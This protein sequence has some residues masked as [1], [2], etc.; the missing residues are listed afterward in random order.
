MVTAS[1]VGYGDLG[2]SPNN[3][4]S[5]VFTVF[6]IFVGVI[7]VFAQL[8][9]IVSKFFRPVFRWTRNLLETVFPQEAIDI[10]GDGSQ[11]FKVPR[12]PLIY[13]SKNLAM[14][15]AFII[16]MQ[17]CFAAVF[18]V[19]E[20]WTYGDAI[21]HC[22]VTATTVGYGD[23]RIEHDAG[24]MWAFFHIVIS[25]SLL[26]AIIADV[27]ELSQKRAAALHKLTLLE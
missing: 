27:D 17:C 18:T 6:A 13:Y 19:L 4:G 22:L 26:A 1:T 14:P 20:D 25:V 10:D 7:V 24:R 11:D 5:R 9:R 15:I 3:A 12:R 23:V 2:P 8:S 16:C 21:Y